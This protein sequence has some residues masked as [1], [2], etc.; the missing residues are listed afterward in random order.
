MEISFL[1]G[2]DRYLGKRNSH[3]QVLNNIL[4]FE[5]VSKTHFSQQAGGNPLQ[6]DEICLSK[7]SCGLFCRKREHRIHSQSVLKSSE[8][9]IKDL[10][11]EYPFE[12]CH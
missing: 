4:P 2:K 7:I 10:V 8:E 6:T 11:T 12:P 3:T 1:G 9:K 5:Y